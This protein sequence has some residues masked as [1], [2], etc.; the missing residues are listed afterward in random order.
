[1]VRGKSA[2]TSYASGDW[3]SR[4]NSTLVHDCL[5]SRRRTAG[6]VLMAMAKCK[7]EQKYVGAFLICYQICSHPVT[8]VRHKVSPNVSSGERD[9][10]SSETGTTKH[11]SKVLYTGKG[12]EWDH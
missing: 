1:M 8:K 6:H 10:A 11:M 2:G 5:S 9:C 12:K 7:S 4:G 3:D